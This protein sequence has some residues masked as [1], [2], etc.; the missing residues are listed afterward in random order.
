MFGKILVCL[1]GSAFA[2]QI[3]PCAASKALGTRREMTLFSV[4]SHDIPF[5][6][7]SFVAPSSFV[8]PDLF[9]AQGAEREI[10][11]KAYLKKVA[12]DL[13]ATGIETTVVVVGGL[14]A[15]ISDIIVGY[16][17]EHGHDLIAMA[18]HGYRGLKRLVFGSITEAVVRK[19][20]VPVLAVRPNA[21]SAR[22]S[23]IPDRAASLDF[24]AE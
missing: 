17:V 24:A 18:T 11:M 7:L 10:N 19:S 15:D 4:A 20:P 1:D 13:Q 5:H 12:G 21:P 6:A 9:D 23:E 3:L 16:S 2:E 22:L 8:P 14:L